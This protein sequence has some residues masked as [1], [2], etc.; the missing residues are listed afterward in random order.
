MGKK[1]VWAAA[2]ISGHLLAGLAEPPVS[3]REQIMLELQRI[4]DFAQEKARFFAHEHQLM[5]AEADG[6]NDFWLEDFFS[7]AKA[8]QRIATC[9]EKR[10]W[11]MENPT[12]LWRDRIHLQLLRNKIYAEYADPEELLAA[13]IL[14]RSEGLVSTSM[15]LFS[16]VGSAIVKVSSVIVAI[17][18]VYDLWPSPMPCSSDI[19]CRELN[20]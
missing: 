15:R 10:L 8:F 19:E 4:A 20:P 1:W 12:A 13:G 7:H 6:D 17:K 18:S 3:E 11:V 2:M 14:R 5:L 16:G 9:A